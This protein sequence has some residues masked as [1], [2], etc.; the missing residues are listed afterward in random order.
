MKQGVGDHGSLQAPPPLESI[1]PPQIDCK[2]HDE[3]IDCLI[4]SVGPQHRSEG[5]RRKVVDFVRNIIVS[6]F[7]A[8]K[9]QLMISGV[10]HSSRS[11]FVALCAW[12]SPAMSHFPNSWAED[13]ESAGGN[14][15]CS[16]RFGSFEDIPT[17]WR[18]RYCFISKQWPSCARV[19]ARDSFVCP[20]TSEGQSIAHKLDNQLN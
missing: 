20:H 19:L 8:R 10:T 6:G 9:V 12:I 7:L 18:Y 17:R 5:R 14:L 3:L 15:F 13:Q 4:R 2:R 16:F 11:S 1:T